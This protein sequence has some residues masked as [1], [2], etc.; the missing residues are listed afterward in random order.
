M[1][2]VRDGTG[3]HLV[4]VVTAV[5]SAVTPSYDYC[6]GDHGQIRDTCNPEIQ[7]PAPCALTRSSTFRVEMPWGSRS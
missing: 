4:G 2:D 7:L 5:A 6:L 3:P 1:G